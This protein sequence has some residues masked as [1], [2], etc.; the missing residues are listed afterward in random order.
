MYVRGVGGAGE[1][2]EDGLLGGLGAEKTACPSREPMTPLQG[3][4]S[5]LSGNLGRANVRLLRRCRSRRQVRSARNRDLTD[6]G[7]AD[8]LPEVNTVAAVP[9]W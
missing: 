5:L 8:Q 6:R 9:I 3:P 4:E 2:T 1:G 7:Q